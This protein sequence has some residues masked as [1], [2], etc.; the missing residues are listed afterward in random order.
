MMT[1]C[2]DFTNYRVQENRRVLTDC[3][4]RSSWVLYLVD[5]RWNQNAEK[6]AECRM[7]NRLLILV[8]YW[9]ELGTSLIAT[10]VLRIQNNAGLQ[11]VGRKWH[12]RIAGYVCRELSN[13]FLFDDVSTIEFKEEWWSTAKG[14]LPNRGSKET[15]YFRCDLIV[16]L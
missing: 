11:S 3:T 14:N 4:T 10:A 13:R 8:S 2:P 7:P 15:K 12:R 5:A 9:F 6:K 16:G 1:V